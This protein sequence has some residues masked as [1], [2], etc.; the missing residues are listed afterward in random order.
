[1]NDSL[2][3][4]VSLHEDCFSEEN[5]KCMMQTTELLQLEIFKEC[6]NLIPEI[7]PLDRGMNDLIELNLKYAPQLQCLVDIEHVGSQIPYV[8]SKLVVLHLEGMGN[9][10]ELCNGPIS[11][12]STNNLK[13]LAIEDSENLRSLFKCSLNLQSKDHKTK[14]DSAQC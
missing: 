8:F 1:M 4:C 6:I 9:L 7:V 3:K 10:E 2:S 12:D 5:I 14:I 11:I 13:E